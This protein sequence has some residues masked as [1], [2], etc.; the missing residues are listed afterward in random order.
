M[1]KYVIKEEFPEIEMELFSKTYPCHL[2][3]AVYVIDTSIPS[4]VIAE[5]Y[6]YETEFINGEWLLK[7]KDN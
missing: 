7:T 3:L 6:V 2:I 5:A 1:K 4:R